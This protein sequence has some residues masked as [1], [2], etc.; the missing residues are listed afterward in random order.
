M[1]KRRAGADETVPGTTAGAGGA[2]TEIVAV[3]YPPT[4]ST[5]PAA[6]SQPEPETEL[7]PQSWS[8]ATAPGR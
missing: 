2:E 5:P 3:D 1:P 6:W 4:G 8:Q 7:L